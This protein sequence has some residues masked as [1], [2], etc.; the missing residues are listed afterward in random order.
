MALDVVIAPRAERDLEDIGS[1]IA[2]DDPVAAGEVISRFE[3]MANLLGDRPHIGAPVLLPAR[4][5]LRKMSMPPYIV[6]YRVTETR[7]EIVRVLHSARD[8]GDMS[9][10]SD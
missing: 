6:F 5:G 8:I 10:F 9:L 7:V 2:A 1:Y 3:R 4:T